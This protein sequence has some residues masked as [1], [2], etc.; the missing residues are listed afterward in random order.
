MYRNHI[1]HSNIGQIFK[2]IKHESTLDQHNIDEKKN[3]IKLHHKTESE[4][5]HCNPNRK[6]VH[7]KHHKNHNHIQ[8]CKI[9]NSEEK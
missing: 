8:E 3:K 1:Y 7:A 6:L 9:Q 5:L 4:N 2:S